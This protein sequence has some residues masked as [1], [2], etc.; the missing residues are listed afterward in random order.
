MSELITPTGRV[1]WVGTGMSTGSGLGLVCAGASTV[2][3]GRTAQKAEDCLARLGLAGAAESREFSPAALAEA[4]APGD[5]VVSMLPA[6]EHPGLVRLAREEGAH[7]VCSSY[8]SPGVAE[9]ARPA[10]DRGCVVLTEVGL[11]PGIDHLLAHDLVRRGRAAVG[12][13][14]A[15]ARFT[16]YCGS[17]PAEPNEFRYRFS[18]APR[19]VLTA[20]LNP[21][22][23]IEDG[24]EKVVERPWEAVTTQEVGDETFEVY[25]NRDSL[26]FVGTYAFPA[27]WR[28]A[29]FVRG[30][31]RLDGWS[32]AWQPVFAALLEADE[33][34]I[35]D[36]AQ[37]LAARYPTSAE[38]H[39]RVVMSVRL[40][41]TA[42]DGR[43]WSGEYALDAVGDE[44]ESA[45]PRLVSVPLALAILDVVDGRVAPGL[46]QA[47]DRPELVAR[48]LELLAEKGVSARYHG[49]TGEEIHG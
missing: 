36:L 44:K 34:A 17:N 18:W 8:L 15:T 31:L 27:G 48:W 29:T 25:P 16:S 32:R 43:T 11:D 6:G 12:D 30:T 39:D 1:H 2:L 47:S 19:G 37:E 13:G 22:R 14:P 46:H 9:E 42:E 45:T 21:A 41:L 40:E 20:L 26:P 7:F 10:A 49:G 4:L 5:V 23:L 28:L 38:D 3:W 24:A 35:T 33:P